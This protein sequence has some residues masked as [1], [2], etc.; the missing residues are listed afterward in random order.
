M[1]QV[2]IAGKEQHT[3]SIRELFQEY[4]E[5]GSTKLYEEF[6]VKFDTPQLVESSMQHLDWFMPPM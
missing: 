3:Q 6:S 5:W 2:I 4:L 1:I